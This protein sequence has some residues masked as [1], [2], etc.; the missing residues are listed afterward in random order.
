MKNTQNPKTVLQILK[1]TDTRLSGE[2]IAQELNIS[3]AAVW[4]R[5]EKLRE[6]GFKID[7]QPRS[8]YSLKSSP[9]ALIPEEIESGLDHESM[10]AGNIT[11]YKTI[12]STNLIAKKMAADG[13]VE[14]TI[15]IAEEQTRGRGR[16]NRQWISPPN[17]NI[18]FSIIFRP[19]I[20]L[21][22]IFS[23][24][25]LT[26][27]S[28]VKAIEKSSGLKAMIKWPNDIYINRL[29]AGGILT[30]FD[31][32][33]DQINFVVV[34]IGLNVNFDPSLSS[35]IQNG[36]TSLSKELGKKISRVKLL[37]EILK[38]INKYYNL[39]KI[40][41]D[42]IYQIHKEWNTYS[43]ITGEPVRITSF[44]STED[45]VAESVDPDGCLIFRDLNGKRK[46]I[47]FGDVSLRV[48]E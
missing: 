39:I 41:I 38:E 10:F 17:K 1:D 21:A 24:T 13:A 30:E 15:V 7:A 4:K 28:V 45:G 12:D 8:G 16:L 44:N 40:D 3:R 33:Q 27:L 48:A 47:V 43:L 23:L 29:K 31:G 9:D 46:K 22:Q 32:E 19:Q 34:G 37:R 11:Y 14:G 42:N 36:A 5:I 25:M 20:L 18:L 35:D 26:S 2:K 6:E